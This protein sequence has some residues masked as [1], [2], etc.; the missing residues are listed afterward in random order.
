MVFILSGFANNR[1]IVFLAT[2]WLTTTGFHRWLFDSSPIIVRKIV[3][4][5]V[6]VVATVA[7]VV[8]AVA[9]TA[10]VIAAVAVV[11]AVVIAAIFYGATNFNVYNGSN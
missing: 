5:A 11:A 1:K 3:I 4:A 10:V 9:A 7:V 8:A 6:A 2:V